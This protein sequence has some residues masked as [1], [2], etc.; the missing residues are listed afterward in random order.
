MV[1]ATHPANAS[2]EQA[3]DFVSRLGDETIKIVTSDA[4]TN[5]DKLQKL[6]ELFNKSVDTKWIGR[7][8]M[9]RYWRQANEEQQK[10]YLTYYAKYLTNSY[11]PRFRE[12]NNQELVIT[13]FY[14]EKGEENEYWVS[15]KIH[16]QDEADI[17]VDYR[18][19]KN[20]AGDYQIIDVVAEGIS[21]ITTQRSE[22]GSILSR[23]GVD[24]LIE[25]L[26]AKS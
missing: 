11:V 18:I 23:K 12:Y 14:Q 1:C 4:S 17:K 20:A 24:F 8:V 25:K 21:L 2:P 26:K 6:S 3:R 9:G 16:S 19:I 22:F 13:D 7:F 15:T 5:E 10:E